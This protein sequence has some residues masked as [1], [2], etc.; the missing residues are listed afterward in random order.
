MYWK[1][2]NMALYFTDWDALATGHAIQIKDILEMKRGERLK[3]LVLDRNV[4][5]IAF[6]QNP[7]NMPKS[8]L[9]FFRE[10][11]AIYT[12]ESGLMGRGFC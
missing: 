4:W 8:P 9:E 2:I 3:V 6:A 7:E 1:T 5:D 11:S 10:N 12:H